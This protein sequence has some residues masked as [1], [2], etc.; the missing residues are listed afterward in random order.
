MTNN[1]Q[2][3]TQEKLNWC[4]AAVA[5]TVARYFSESKFEQCDIAK[6]VLM[7][8]SDDCPD[9]TDKAASFGDTLD[10]LNKML[11][12]QLNNKALLGQPLR[13]DEIKAQIDSGRP[14]CVRIEWDGDDGAHVV[15]ISGYSS[16]KSGQQWLDISDP[17]YEDSTVTYEN[18]KDA[19]LDAGKWTDTYL[20]GQP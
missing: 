20:V 2:I 1:F 15:M 16:S 14:V 4:W 19:Y 10:I 11:P 7:I 12:R 3:Q 5:A 18:F 8:Q 6:K 17:Y 13:F 9:S